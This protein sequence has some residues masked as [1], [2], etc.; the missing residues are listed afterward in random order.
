VVDLEMLEDHVRGFQI[1]Y[2]T[3]DA[4]LGTGEARAEP[5]IDREKRIGEIPEVLPSDLVFGAVQPSEDEMEK[6]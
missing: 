3:T 4:D 6:Q 5:E 2:R 1:C